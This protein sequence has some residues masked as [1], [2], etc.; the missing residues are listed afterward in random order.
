M[1][2]LAV[3]LGEPGREAAVDGLQPG[4]QLCLEG[5][6]VLAELEDPV[7]VQVGD[8]ELDRSAA[9]GAGYVSGREEGAERGERAEAAWLDGCRARAGQPAR[10][11]E[12]ERDQHQRGQRSQDR[13]DQ[14]ERAR[15]R[16]HGHEHGG[17]PR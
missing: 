17:R 14:R 1:E 10:V 5:G 11:D 9:L 2:Q 13:P 12:R 6:D 4:A 15:D 16:A 3:A 7:V 8:S